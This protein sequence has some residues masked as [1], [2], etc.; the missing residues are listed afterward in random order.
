MHDLFIDQAK[1]VW[2]F[3]LSA[4]QEVHDKVGA[5]KPNVVIGALPKYVLKLLAQGKLN[6]SKRKI[7][8]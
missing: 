1:K 7:K 4:Y 8:Q 6:N 2:S 5:L 3:N